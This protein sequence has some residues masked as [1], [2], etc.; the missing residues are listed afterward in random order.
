MTAVLPIGTPA[1]EIARAATPGQLTAWAAVLLGV[2][3]FL[4]LSIGSTGITLAALPRVLAALIA[5]HSDAGIAREQLV[6]LDIRL[7]RMLLGAFVDR[8]SPCPA[9]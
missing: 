5:G 8:R 9:P 6:L 2:A 1:R 7:P 4:S 3:A